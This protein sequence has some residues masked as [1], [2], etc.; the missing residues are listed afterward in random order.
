MQTTHVPTAEHSINP[1]GSLVNVLPIA[2][3][4]GALLGSTDPVYVPFHAFSACCDR[5]NAPSNRTTKKGDGLWR[6]LV[7]HQVQ[8]PA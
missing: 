4:S 2:H 5:A 8:I 1:T 3:R 7:R 6:D